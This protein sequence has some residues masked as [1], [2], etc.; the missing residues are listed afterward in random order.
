MSPLF[1]AVSASGIGYAPKSGAKVLL[2]FE[3]G[4]KKSNNLLEI[5]FLRK[6]MRRNQRDR[7]PNKEQ[8]Q[9]MSKGIARV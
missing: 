9:A 8:T 3:I 6:K 4:K 1:H 5:Y 2:F 7:I